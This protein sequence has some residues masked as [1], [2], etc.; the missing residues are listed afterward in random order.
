MTSRER[1][2]SII[3]DSPY[4]LD[5]A[6]SGAEAAWPGQYKSYLVQLAWE[7][8]QSAEAE[9]ARKCAEIADRADKSTHPSDL[10]D[11]IRAAF[12]EAFK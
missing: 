11:A 1:F 12:P 7:F 6:R 8:W 5:A 9:T 2:E 10:A 4:S 3:K